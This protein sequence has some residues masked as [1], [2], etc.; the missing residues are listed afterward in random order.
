[1]RSTF[2]NYFEMF[3][4]RLFVVRNVTVFVLIHPPRSRSFSHAFM[5]GS[6][7]GR[8]DLLHRI[9]ALFSVVFEL[10]LAV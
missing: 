3:S 2:E 5:R 9:G 10:L 4:C 1:M 7:F 8:S 6:F